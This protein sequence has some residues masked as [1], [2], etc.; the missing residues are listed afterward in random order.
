[1]VGSRTVQLVSVA[2][3]CV[4]RHPRFR[5]DTRTASRAVDI[6]TRA[7]SRCRTGRAPEPD[8]SSP[9]S[10]RATVSHAPPHPIFRLPSLESARSERALDGSWSEFV[11]RPGLTPA[12]RGALRQPIHGH[13]RTT[14]H[15][16]H[17]MSE[18]R[19]HEAVVT[20]ATRLTD[21]RQSFSRIVQLHIA[22]GSPPVPRTG[23]W[24]ARPPPTGTRRNALREP[25][26]AQAGLRAPRSPTAVLGTNRPTHGSAIL[27]PS[28]RVT[29][30]PTR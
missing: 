8:S 22:S 30:W 20:A 12:S 28:S 26:A 17:I 1:M 15:A 21:D 13:R 3:V 29:R 10:R 19:L 25:T 14:T 6:P 18:P 24:M 11:H 27:A 5:R 7:E 16:S 4:L 9:P 23:G 2:S